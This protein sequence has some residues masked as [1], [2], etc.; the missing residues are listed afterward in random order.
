[1][2][3]VWLEN[4]SSVLVFTFDFMK[5]IITFKCQEYEPVSMKH[6]QLHVLNTFQFLS[7]FL[8]C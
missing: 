2:S 1:M 6:G 5:Q 3:I 8:Y 7:L 4:R